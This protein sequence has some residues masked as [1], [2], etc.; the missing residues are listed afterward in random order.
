MN[1]SVTQVSGK[2]ITEGLEVVLSE[3]SQS[4]SDELNNPF[5]PPKIPRSKQSDAAEKK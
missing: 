3:K 4:S 5:A 1:G 2:L